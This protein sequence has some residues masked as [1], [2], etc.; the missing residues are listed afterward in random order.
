M[1]VCV[2]ACKQIYRDRGSDGEK[3]RESYYKELAH[4]TVEP[5]K[6]QDLQGESAG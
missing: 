4:M 5:S 1:C 3:K 2:C 6:S